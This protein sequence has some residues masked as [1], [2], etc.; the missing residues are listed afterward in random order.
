[1]PASTPAPGLDL[2]A[3]FAERVAD[4]RAVVERCAADELGGP[5]RRRAA[6]RALGSSYRP[7]SGSTSPAPSST[8]ASLRPS[9]TAS[10]P[11]SPRARVGIA[12]T[13]TIVLD[14]G[15]G[16]GRRALTLVPDRHVCV[17]RADQVVADVPDAVALLDASPAADLDQ[18][19]VAPPAT[20]S[21]T[22]SRA[23]TAPRTCT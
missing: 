19:P 13:G 16:Q 12:E 20:S 5:G 2:V 14:H 11:S 15:P 23:S 3:L 17:V 22:G 21:S 6:R 4:Y 8:P 9:S 1:M 10:T 18:R 7:G